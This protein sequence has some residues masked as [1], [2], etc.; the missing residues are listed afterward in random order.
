MRIVQTAH[1]TARSFIIFNFIIFKEH[2]AAGQ[3]K[4]FAEA[5]ASLYPD[6]AEIIS[7]NIFSLMLDNK[8]KEIDAEH[9]DVMS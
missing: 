5:L 7:K 6:C 2:G 9:I 4:C 1:G 3:Q 8:Q